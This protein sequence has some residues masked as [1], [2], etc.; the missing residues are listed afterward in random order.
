[1]SGAIRSIMETREP[2]SSAGGRPAGTS[3]DVEFNDNQGHLAVD[4]EALRRLVRR[5]LEAEGIERASVSVVLVAD[6]TIQDVNRRFLNHDWS[7]DV[8]GFPLSEPGEPDLHGELIVSAE[9][10][11][12]TAR[13]A[14]GDPGTEIALYVVH[15]LLHWC[16][17]D[18]Q[19]A[20]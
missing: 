5:V 2:G 13:A 6:A 18:D 16:G 8:I 11:V 1:F 3:I 15:G 7:T 4:H 17:F 14:G 12:V 20:E 9:R 19:T 10:A